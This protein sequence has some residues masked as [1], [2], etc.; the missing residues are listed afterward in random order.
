MKN[1]TIS[2][3]F[4]DCT[5]NVEIHKGPRGLGLSVS[6]GVDS[7]AAYPGLIR[8]KRLFPHQS[9]WATGKLQAGDILLEAN[10][11]SLSGLTNNEALEVLRTLENDVNLL[12]CRPLDEKYRKLSPATNEPPA[13][14][15]RSSFMF[16]QNPYVLE[17]LEPLQTN[18]ADGVG[19]L[20]FKNFINNF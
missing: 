18:F 11:I 19:I 17:P 20:K 13:P 8:I 6:G 7:T 4:P 14:P 3:F 1:Q 2:S 12:V 10:G 5:F 15:M 16:K 9:A